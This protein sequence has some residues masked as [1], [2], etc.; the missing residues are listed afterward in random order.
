MLKPSLILSG[1]VVNY[2]RVFVCQLSYEKNYVFY[3]LVNI[4]IVG[5]KFFQNNFNEEDKSGPEVQKVT[6]VKCRFG[7]YNLRILLS[8]LSTLQFGD[9][10]AKCGPLYKANVS[11]E[12]VAAQPTGAA[13]SADP[14]AAAATFHA[15][16]PEQQRKQCRD[17]WNPRRQPGK[18]S[19]SIFKSD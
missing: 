8:N 10:A 12:S 17:V 11:T 15:P 1:I 14:V 5:T 3:L 6:A 16:G 13:A 18:F 2:F 4:S 19:S 9:S 7:N